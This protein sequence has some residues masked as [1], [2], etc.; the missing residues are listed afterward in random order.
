MLL[1][2]VNMQR[3]RLQQRNESSHAAGGV[4]HRR[5]WAPT[6]RGH[7]RTRAAPASARCRLQRARHDGG[8]CSA[9]RQRAPT[10]RHAA[11]AHCTRAL[12]DIF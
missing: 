3:A 1:H 4:G 10:G 7:R 12:L 6:L 9:A 11:V 2:V 8:F 5:R